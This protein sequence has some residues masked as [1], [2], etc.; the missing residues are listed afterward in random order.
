MDKKSRF[1]VPF[2]DLREVSIIND[3]IDDPWYRK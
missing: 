2:I 1:T 3:Q